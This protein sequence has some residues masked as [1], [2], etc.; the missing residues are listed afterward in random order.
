MHGGQRLPEATPMPL[1]P[2]KMKKTK[3]KKEKRRMD[4]RKGEEPKFL[5]LSWRKVFSSRF[6]L[7]R[8][9]LDATSSYNP[10]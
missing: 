6:S 1:Q 8:E 10:N 2:K 5:P 3:N 9:F 4:G 7:E